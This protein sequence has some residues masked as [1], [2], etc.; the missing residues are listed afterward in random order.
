MSRHALAVP[1]G[2]W[3]FSAERCS[4]ACCE[5]RRWPVAVAT[6]V[7]F[8]FGPAANLDAR[9]Q[10]ARSLGGLVGGFLSRVRRCQLDASQ[11]T[12]HQQEH[13]GDGQLGSRN[14]FIR[15]NSR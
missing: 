15:C 10:A 5:R 11:V 2:P 1:T 9:R 13:V 3:A 6:H 7:F 14:L 4:R 8:S 12:A